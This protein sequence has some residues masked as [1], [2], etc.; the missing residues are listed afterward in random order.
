MKSRILSQI[1]LANAIVSKGFV[2]NNN[3]LNKVF[4][5]T[6]TAG[7][8]L[9][10][11][12]STSSSSIEHLPQ[13]AVK[14]TITVPGSETQS[15]YN[16]ALKDCTKQVTIPGFRKGSRIPAA[17]VENHLAQKGQKNAVRTA[18][19]N[20]LL[21]KVIE[22]ALKEDHGLEPIGQPTLA[23]ATEELANRFVPGDDL[24]MVVN[25]DVWPTTLQWKEE[26][27]DTEKYEKPYYGLEGTYKRAPFDEVKFEKALFDLKERYVTLAPKDGEGVAL[28]MEDAC[29]VNMVGYMTKDDDGKTKGEP[30]PSSVASG[31]NVEVVLQTGKYMEGLVEG[32]VGGKVGETIEVFVSFPDKLKDK[33]LA[34]KKAIFDVTVNEISCRTY[35]EVDDEFAD[36][37]RK[38]LTAQSLKDELRKAVD[39]EEIRASLNA[40]NECLGKALIP[41]LTI[42]IPDTILTNQAREKYAVM[43]TEMRDQGMADAEIK[44]LITPD[45]FLKY[46]KA[47]TSMI[48]NDFV[49]SFACEKIALLEDIETPAYEVAEQLEQLREQAKKEGDDADFDESAVRPKVEATLQ[50]RLVYDLLAEKANLT[51][52]YS[53][54]PEFDADLMEKLA[55]ESL[56]REQQ[57]ISTSDTDSEVVDAEIE[58]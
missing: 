35:P 48:T 39:D 56:E 14:V 53:L 47:A 12:M 26:Y 3:P 13:S 42:S 4:L 34:G 37:V 49:Q 18:A 21:N 25:C 9:P 29:M 15:A 51:P 28:E 30:L 20:T 17:V 55:N 7:P 23:E 6:A 2:L 44:K 52:D 57:E 1:I 58:S 8:T 31:D 11:Y 50:R 41:R 32:L 33:S 36:M 40:R 54:E 16:N 43:M 5:S 19:L 22:P 45:N 24:E 10:L 46:K 27:L 38:G